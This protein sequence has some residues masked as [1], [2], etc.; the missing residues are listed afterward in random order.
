MFSCRVLQTGDD[1]SVL[2]WRNSPDVAPYMFRDDPISEAEH[3]DWFVTALEDRPTSRVRIFTVN[4]VPNGL[5]SLSDIDQRHRNCV[6]GGYLSPEA[7][8]G[9]RLGSA[10]MSVSLTMVFEELGLHRVTVEAIEDNT[11]AI[12]LYESVGFRREGLLRDRAHQNRGYV[13]VVV[14]GLLRDEWLPG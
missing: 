1:S 12:A 9:Q 3:A 6:W 5:F 2:R 14:L 8:R 13:N 7:P 11:R 4:D 10:M